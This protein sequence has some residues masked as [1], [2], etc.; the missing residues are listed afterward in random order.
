MAYIRGFHAILC[1]WQSKFYSIGELK[2]CVL[3]NEPYLAQWDLLP[4]KDCLG[5]N[6]Q[7][8]AA[9]LWTSQYFH[10]P[11]SSPS[12]FFCSVTMIGCA[13]WGRGAKC[14][15]SE[16]KPVQ[17][18][19]VWNTPCSAESFPLKLLIAWLFVSCERKFCCIW[20]LTHH[21]LMS[22]P[23]S[24]HWICKG[25]LRFR[26]STPPCQWMTHPWAPAFYLCL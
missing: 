13:F 8:Q 4:W 5:Y 25:C 18:K 20:D 21:L 3:R 19:C 12:S 6:F 1:L 24:A 15:N 26:F 10:T 23:N 22:K 14:H 9:L 7:G 2:H 16:L 11:S 17:L